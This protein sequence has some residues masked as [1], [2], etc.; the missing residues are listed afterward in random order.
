MEKKDRLHEW[1][2]ECSAVREN[3]VT[4]SVAA[5]QWLLKLRAKTML[6]KTSEKIG[7]S[8]MCRLKADSHSNSN[9][10]CWLTWRTCKSM[11]CIHDKMSINSLTPCKNPF[12]RLF[13]QPLPGLWKRKSTVN[14][15]FKK[16]KKSMLYFVETPFTVRIWILDI[17]KPETI[18][19]KNFEGQFL[20]DPEFK[21]SV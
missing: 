21:W 12:R 20:Y 5:E 1:E 18:N 14:Y 10:T 17:R 11:P 13:S 19:K 9:S 6:T 4:G 15:C 8:L 3:C 7:A 16:F 2:S